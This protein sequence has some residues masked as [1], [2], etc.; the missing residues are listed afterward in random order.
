MFRLKCIVYIFL[1]LFCFC[2]DTMYLF[3]RNPQLTK[4]KNI[5]KNIYYQKK[6]TKNKKIFPVSKRGKQFYTTGPHRPD[7][8]SFWGN[9]KTWFN[10]NVYK[11]VTAP[12]FEPFENTNLYQYKNNQDLFNKYIELLSK[13][14]FF[15]EK[16]MVNAIKALEKIF[17][18]MITTIERGGYAFISIKRARRIALDLLQ[19]KTEGIDINENATK[20]YAF[21]NYESSWKEE[22]FAIHANGS[23]SNIITDI[24]DTYKEEEKDP[25]SAEEIAGKY[26]RKKFTENNVSLNYVD[27]LSL[28]AK[29][30]S[31]INTYCGRYQEPILLKILDPLHIPSSTI[32]TI[33][34]RINLKVRTKNLINDEYNNK[35][36][37]KFNNIIVQNYEEAKKISSQVVV[38]LLHIHN[39]NSDAM[40]KEIDSEIDREIDWKKM[41]QEAELQTSKK[42]KEF[43]RAFE[44]EMN[45][46]KYQQQNQEKQQH[47]VENALKILKLPEDTDD[48]NII[49]AAHRRLTKIYHPDRPQNK[50]K[51]IE[52]TQ[53]MQ[54]INDALEILLAYFKN[55]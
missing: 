24:F 45:K 11:K 42:Q 13:I 2:V 52:A 26:V 3:R 35:G 54:E 7:Q 16:E 47:E 30:L 25:I 36:T 33:L 51:Q 17:K 5:H 28:V 46:R 19:A 38:E 48:I 8:R 6:F 29:T 20:L 12:R 9:V 15:N 49:K 34:S 44:E 18:E 22:L 23:V 1:V 50:D 10:E 39:I 43:E 53:K 32:K 55:K 4:Q 14:E 31:I 27:Y 21:G 40:F 37:L 41:Q